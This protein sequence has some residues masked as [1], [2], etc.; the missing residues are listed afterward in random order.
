MKFFKI[1]FRFTIVFS[2]FTI[3]C[4]FLEPDSFIIQGKTDFE[5]GLSV[6]R[7]KAGPNGQPIALDTT[8][9]V[10]GTFKF[11]GS[12]T[13]IDL[14][15]IF[16][17]GVKFESPII[18]E[19]G[20]IEA[21]IFKDDLNS[22]TIRGTQSN[23]DLEEYR[24]STKIYTEKLQ[25]IAAE[26]NQANTFGDNIL[27]DDLT[28][29]YR[30]IEQE[31][32]FFE[33]EF[34]NSRPGSYIAT[35]I[36]ERLVFTKKVPQ[37]EAVAIFNGFE[38][39]IKESISGKKIYAIISKPI[40]PSSIGEVSPSFEAPNQFGDILSLESM[41]GKVT[42]IDFWASWCRPCRIE[43]PNLV[44]LYKRMH[45][46]GLEIISVSLDKNKASW[47][48]A[49][50]DDGLNWNHV[51]SLQYWKEPVA[52]LYGVRSIPKAFILDENGVI[53]AK[54]L[55]GAQ[56]DAKIEEILGR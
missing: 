5:D 50:K 15:F 9:I 55:R 35:L 53:V 22:S 37:T 29:E 16:I 31:L 8:Q 44:R 54:D 7:I 1:F 39:K 30:I 28:S 12:I 56:L 46:K 42:I 17:E 45:E 41:K 24:V 34:M 52:L 32:S 51:S 19:E 38:Q 47:I 11:E 43:N 36:L 20:I 14:N 40:N 3:S 4:N 33:K 10:K 27:V 6:Y 13:Q 23:N 49:I 48:Q 25:S 21:E 2:L 18:I 26:I